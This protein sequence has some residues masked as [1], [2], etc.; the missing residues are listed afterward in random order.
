MMNYAP[1]MEISPALNATDASYFQSL[2]G[3]LYL[4]V[5]IGR[6]G[7]A[8]EISMLSSHLAYTQEIHLMTILHVMAYMKYKHNSH[9]VFDPTYPTVNLNTFETG[10]EWKEF[11]CGTKGESHQIL[12]HLVE[13]R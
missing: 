1:E 11:Y 10:T 13:M 3:I 6:I 2:I 4:T 8:T 12:L 9:L 7:I 5:E